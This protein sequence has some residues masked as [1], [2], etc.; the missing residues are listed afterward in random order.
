MGRDGRTVRGKYKAKK[1][2]VE[3]DDD[4]GMGVNMLKKGRRHR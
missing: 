2:K 1:G 4:R 3:V